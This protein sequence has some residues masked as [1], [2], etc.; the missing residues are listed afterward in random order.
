MRNLV[1]WPLQQ[2]KNKIWYLKYQEN[3]NHKKNYAG[4]T[5]PIQV[6][7]YLTRITR[8]RSRTQSQVQRK[9]TEMVSWKH[10]TVSKISILLPCLYITHK[11]ATRFTSPLVLITAISSSAIL[12]TT[13][14]LMYCLL[15]KLYRRINVQSNSD[16][17]MEII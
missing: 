7:R 15:K 13:N 4:F 6:I 11:G 17:Q 10:A 16:F 1:R 3:T 12:I 5:K 8:H 9:P 14:L 2:S